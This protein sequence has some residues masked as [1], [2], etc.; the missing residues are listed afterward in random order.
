MAQSQTQSLVQTV[1]DVDREHR[2]EGVTDD[3]F[4]LDEFHASKVHYLSAWNE[5][6]IRVNHDDVKWVFV[7]NYEMFMVEYEKKFIQLPK[8]KEFWKGVLIAGGSVGR[9][10][11]G[12]FGGDRSDIDVF[13]YG[14]TVEEANDKI[15]NIFTFVKANHNKVEYVARTTNCITFSCD[16]NVVQ[17]ILRIYNSI[18]EILHGFD[19]GS[20]A[21]GFDNKNVYFTTLSCFA[22]HNKCN[23][24]DCTK[25]SPSYEYRLVKYSRRKFDVILPKLDI[26]KLRDPAYYGKTVEYCELPRMA[27]LYTGINQNEIQHAE[28]DVVA[29]ENDYNPIDVRRVSIIQHNIRLLLGTTTEADTPDYWYFGRNI[30]DV[31]KGTAVSHDD[32]KYTYKIISAPLRRNG[33]SITNLRRYFGG[34]LVD[35]IIE[36][37]MTDKPNKGKIRKIVQTQMDRLKKMESVYATPLVWTT[38]NPITQLSSSFKPIIEDERYWYIEYL[39]ET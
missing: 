11:S 28:W 38:K 4:T 15:D 19:L 14:L 33:F 29:F 35:K 30:N 20:S 39:L 12:C 24:V 1:L 25:R 10:V 9:V 21:V 18:S 32:I 16:R 2:Y 5:P 27:F 7:D 22:Y 31:I 34:D 37:K 13:L 23:I 17:I 6:V 26:K 36:I 3:L 8:N